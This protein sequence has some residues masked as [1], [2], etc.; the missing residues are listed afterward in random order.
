M[1]DKLRRL[2]IPFINQ[3]N[4]LLMGIIYLMQQLKY[5]IKV[6]NL[7]LGTEIDYKLKEYSKSIIAKKV[8]DLN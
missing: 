3:I 5:I 2:I 1:I 8:K 6:E 4:S 7:E